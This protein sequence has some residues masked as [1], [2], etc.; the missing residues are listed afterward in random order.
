MDDIYTKVLYEI[1]I[2]VD[3]DTC[4][5]L[6]QQCCNNLGIKSIQI[7]FEDSDERHL[8]TSCIHRGTG[9]SVA[10]DKI[11]EEF[12]KNNIKIIRTKVE[13]NPE[14]ILTVN[15]EYLYYEIHLEIPKTFFEAFKQMQK[16]NYFS[17]WFISFNMAKPEVFSVTNRIDH[18]HLLDKQMSL[19]LLEDIEIFKRVKFISNDERL[20]F[21]YAIIDDNV[22]L[23]NNWLYK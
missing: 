11:K 7:G 14:Y 2:T 20:L 6:F 21:E 23:D 4:I 18:S 22:S 1:H 8:M 13:T 9:L 12:T 15:K 19:Y 5:N 3:Q 17:N 10:I 16:D